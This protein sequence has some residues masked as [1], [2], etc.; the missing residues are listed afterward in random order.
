MQVVWDL[1]IGDSFPCRFSTNGCADIS[2]SIVYSLQLASYTQSLNPESRILNSYIE[3]DLVDLA[4]A[5]VKA[6]ITGQTAPKP[7]RRSAVKP[8]F[9]TIERKGV[10]VGCRGALDTRAGT[11][12]EEIVFTARAAARHDPRYK[13]LSPKEL[14][15]CRVTVT[16]VDRLEPLDDVSTLLP[17]E[18]LVLKSGDHTGVVL[19]WEGKDP[20]VRLQW[21][22]RKAG[23]PP[24]TACRLSRMKGERYRG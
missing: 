22:Y 15:D 12:E 4:W 24:G 13:P 1:A 6:E 9:V 11:L 21:A 18:G 2:E 14:L 3:K 7:I 20:R 16:V 23:V 8:V 19:P 17:S 10:V 5:A